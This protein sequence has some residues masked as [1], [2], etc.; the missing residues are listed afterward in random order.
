MEE[1]IPLLTKGWTPGGAGIWVVVILMLIGWWKGLPAVLD[2]FAN[3]QS[4]IEERMGKLLDDATERFTRE[5][6]AADARHDDCMKGQE[7]MQTEVER[8]RTCV[9]EQQATIDGLKKQIIQMQVSALRV[10]GNTGAAP[11]AQAVVAKLDKIVGTG[12]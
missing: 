9:N 4:K 1:L 12:E 7:K 6:A 3:R 10:E 8:L 5:I 11:F 2:A